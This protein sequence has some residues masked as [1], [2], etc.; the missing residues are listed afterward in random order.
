M[1]KEWLKICDSHKLYT[2]DKLIRFITLPQINK[3]YLKKAYY[4]DLKGSCT[5]CSN[6]VI[7]TF[8]HTYVKFFKIDHALGQKNYVYISK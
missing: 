7:T 2:H 1:K 5:P 4:I 6:I 8:S 3:V